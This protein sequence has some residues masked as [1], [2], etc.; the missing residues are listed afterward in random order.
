MS[1]TVRPRW[2][3]T[4]LMRPRSAGVMSIVSRAVKA[5]ASLLPVARGSGALIQR[6]GS[7]GRAM[8]ACL[9]ERW[10]IAPASRPRPQ[11]R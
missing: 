2:K 1:A 3:A 8:K 4:T 7:A 9:E 10:V 5:A 11:E 6:S